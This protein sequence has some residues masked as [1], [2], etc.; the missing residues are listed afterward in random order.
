MTLLES[1][2]LAA[3]EDALDLIDS[4]EG[5]QYRAYRQEWERIIEYAK[6]KEVEA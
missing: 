1:T 3:L 4:E 6:K 2:L 5:A